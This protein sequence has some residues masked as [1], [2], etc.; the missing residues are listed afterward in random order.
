LRTETQLTF[1]NGLIGFVTLG[2]Y[3]PQEARVYCAK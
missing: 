3:T 1:L 2:I